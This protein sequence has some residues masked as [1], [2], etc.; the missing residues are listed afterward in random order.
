MRRIKRPLTV[1]L[2][3]FVLTLTG[4]TMFDSVSFGRALTSLGLTSNTSSASLGAEVTAE[5]VLARLEAVLAF[6]SIVLGE[7]I[8]DGLCLSCLRRHTQILY[9]LAI[10]V[11]CSSWESSVGHDIRQLD[12]FDPLG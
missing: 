6:I 4:F 9:S 11:S 8:M 1:V 7:G 5:L 10:P 3:F 12:L 2:R